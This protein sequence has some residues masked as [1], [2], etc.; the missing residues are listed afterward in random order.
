MVRA[1][2]AHS[3]R[4]QA[5][6]TGARPPRSRKSTSV[7]DDKRDDLIDKP[8]LSDEEL[9]MWFSR[10]LNLQ[11]Q[12]QRDYR[13][14]VQAEITRRQTNAQ[15]RVLQGQERQIEAQ[16]KQLE[17]Q[18]KQLEIQAQLTRSLRTASWVLVGATILL[19]FAT[20]LPWIWPRH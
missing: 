4:R 3:G 2:R 7:E 10:M 1:T 20:V 18:G 19:A 9:R 16:G 6:K 11:G 8:Y 15:I 12:A 17:A 5:F 13:E 14:T